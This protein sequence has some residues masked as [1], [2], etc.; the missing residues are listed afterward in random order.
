MSTFA[1]VHGGGGGAW[2]W[3]LVQP[4]LLTLG[5]DPVAIDLP[6]EEPA[7]TLG[8]HAEAMVAA[9]DGRDDVLVVG[10][11][12]G[13]MVAPLVAARLGARA[14]A[15]LYVA[16]MVPRPGESF[17]GWWEAVDHAGAIAER[18]A[19]EGAP[20]AGD[21]ET[22]LQDVEPSLA[23]EALGRARDPHAHALSLPW[24]LERLPDVPARS[25]LCRHDR[26]FPPDLMRRVTR[27]RLGIEPDEMDGGHMPM[28]ARPVELAAW[29]AGCAVPAAGG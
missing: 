3:H 29:L 8:D 12:L 25:L 11:S 20:P 28:L 5:H 13:G 22:F 23:H 17:G 6:I 24:P 16:G 18:D 1:L 2:D 19:H 15:V 4:E 9:L 27:D 26:M 21:L 10:H 7:A 14:S